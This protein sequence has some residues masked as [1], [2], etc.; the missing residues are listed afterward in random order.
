VAVVR[1]VQHPHEGDP[2][3]VAVRLVLVDQHGRCAVEPLSEF[4]IALATEDR[5]GERVGIDEAELI[6]GDGALCSGVP[7]RIDRHSGP[8]GPVGHPVPVRRQP[9]LHAQSVRRHTPAAATGQSRSSRSTRTTSA[10]VRFKSWSPRVACT[11]PAPNCSRP[12]RSRA[13][14]PICTSTST[15]CRPSQRRTSSRATS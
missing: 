9:G 12:A 10:A 3:W 6:G 15:S 5:A 13:N 7:A 11:R 14:L 4:R 8:H 2:P 1:H